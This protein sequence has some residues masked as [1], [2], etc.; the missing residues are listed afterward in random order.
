MNLTKAEIVL[1]PCLAAIA[2]LAAANVLPWAVVIVCAI[3]GALAISFLEQRFP[4]LLG[5][6]RAPRGAARI[7]ARLAA[8]ACIVVLAIVLNEL[9]APTVVN[10]LICALAVV[11]YV[12]DRFRLLEEERRARALERDPDHRLGPSL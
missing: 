10:A 9:G 3:V 5:E 11:P 12:Y 7:L 4:A 8:P 2:G 6:P 1:Y